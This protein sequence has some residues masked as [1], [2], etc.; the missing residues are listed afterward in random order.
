[1]A[2]AGASTDIPCV[3]AGVPFMQLDVHQDGSTTRVSCTAAFPTVSTRSLCIWP[4]KAEDLRQPFLCKAGAYAVV[5]CA[6]ETFLRALSC[7]PA[8]FGEAAGHA[9]LAAEG[10]VVFA[11]EV[12]LGEGG[13]VVAWNCMSGTYRMPDLYACQASLPLDALWQFSPTRHVPVEDRERL[14]LL[15]G[16]GALCPPRGVC[17]SSSSSE[18]VWQHG[19]SDSMSTR[20]WGC[21]EHINK[22]SAGC[23]SAFPCLRSHHQTT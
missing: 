5:R 2:V 4:V 22:R 9:A 19:R 13:C 6:G 20:A 18:L 11:G 10:P 16:G 17:S 21:A 12:L 1:M 3:A 14:H 7:A 15:K 8:R 23:G